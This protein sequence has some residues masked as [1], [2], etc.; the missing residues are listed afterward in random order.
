M[1]HTITA[2]LV[3]DKVIS[4]NTIV[5]CDQLRCTCG[6]EIITWSFGAQKQAIEY[7]HE[8]HGNGNYVRNKT[9]I[10]IRCAD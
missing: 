1:I 8:E 7:I 4:F 2:E 3:V 10:E 6:F 5:P 9:R